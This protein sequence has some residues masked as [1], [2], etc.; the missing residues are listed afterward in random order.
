MP[1]RQTEPSEPAPCCRRSCTDRRDA[2][3]PD[4]KGSPCTVCVPSPS[5]SCGPGCSPTPIPCRRTSA[6]ACAGIRGDLAYSP[7]RPGSNRAGVR[8]VSEA[9]PPV[10]ELSVAV[11]SP[12]VRRCVGQAARR[13]RTFAPRRLAAHGQPL[14]A[15]GIRDAKATE[16]RIRA[17]RVQAPAVAVAVAADGTGPEALAGAGQPDTR[18]GPP[19]RRPRDLTP[20]PASIWIQFSDI[21]GL[22]PVMSAFARDS[23]QGQ[24]NPATA[25]HQY[26][27]PPSV[28]A[29]ASTNGG[30]AVAF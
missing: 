28:P 27:V 11:G 19:A 30:T 26:G 10:A 8:R 12:L 22:L 17:R 15:T 3:R 21:G 13:R 29:E 1:P 6:P 18:N 16:N 20:Y 24:P 23:A 7:V 25:L 9:I 2:V 5:S 14:I 4:W